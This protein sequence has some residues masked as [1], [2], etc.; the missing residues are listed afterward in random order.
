MKMEELGVS[1]GQGRVGSHESQRR[2]AEQ[3]H[4]ACRLVTHELSDCG[5]RHA[6][7]PLVLESRTWR[8]GQRDSNKSAVQFWICPGCAAFCCRGT[9]SCG[10]TGVEQPCL[11]AGR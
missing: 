11:L 4:T 10:A 7:Y 6:T 1:P 8:S 9:P 2:R 3:N 5:Q